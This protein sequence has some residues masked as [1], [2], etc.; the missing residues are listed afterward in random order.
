MTMQTKLD[1]QAAAR[2]AAQ[3]T[4]AHQARQTALLRE[5]LSALADGQGPAAES[6]W[7]GL[8]QAYASDAELRQAWSDYHW[9]GEALRAGD[10]AP[11][12]ANQAFVAG[13]MARIASEEPMAAKPQRIAAQSVSL[14][15]YELPAAN[16]AVFRWKMVAGIATLAAVAAVA[17]HVA[18]VPSAGPQLALGVSPTVP[19]VQ[20]VSGEQSRAQAVVTER[21]VVLRD[22]QLEE[23]LAAHRQY[24]GMSALQ[25]PAGFLRNATYETPQR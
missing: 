4:D 7:S 25:M 24:G 3:P 5:Q 11:A 22:P 2:A 13:V 18:V 17:W 14:D 20:M 10:H 19:A 16:D 9:L 1:T 15:Q 6:D 12:P 23:L 21:G 8:C